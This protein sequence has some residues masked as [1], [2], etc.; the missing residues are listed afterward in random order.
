MPQAIAT[1]R[2]RG[3]L[4]ACGLA[5]GLGL[6]VHPVAAEQ[7]AAP[8]ENGA[9]PTRLLTVADAKYEYLDLAGGVSSGTLRLTYTQPF[10]DARRWAVI[11]RVPLASVDA[12]GDDSFAVGDASLKLSHVFGLTKTQ[13]WVAQGEVIGDTAERPELGTGRNVFKGTLIYARFLGNGAI[14]APAWVQS[15][16]L[17]GSSRRRQVDATTI[18][19]YYVPKVADPRNLVTL[20]P[21]LNFDWQNDLRYLSFS[22]T[23]GRIIGP[24]FGGNAIVFVKPTVFAGGDRPGS[25]GIEVGYRVLG[26]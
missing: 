5:A 15:I 1:H 4:R 21:A 23:L 22:A 18:D 6:L 7:A 8:V 26:F 17:G 9:D 10:G 2:I 13:A 11:A 24:A 19:L 3:C 12:G 25:W 16:D 14:F 20:D